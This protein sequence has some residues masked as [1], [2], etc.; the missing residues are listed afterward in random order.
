MVV[1]GLP[2]CVWGIDACTFIESYFYAVP[3]DLLSPGGALTL[4][5]FQ[6]IQEAKNDLRVKGVTVD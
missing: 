2:T 6:E 3:E 1:Q 4:L 5:W